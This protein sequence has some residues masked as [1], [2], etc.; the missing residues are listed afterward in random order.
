MPPN[1]ENTPQEES[2]HARLMRMMRDTTFIPQMVESFEDEIE[3]LEG[4]SLDT[5]EQV[6]WIPPTPDPISEQI[7]FESEAALNEEMRRNP[8]ILAGG[9][10]VEVGQNGSW[11]VTNS[12]RNSNP[13]PRFQGFGREFSYGGLSGFQHPSMEKSLTKAAQ[14]KL[15]KAVQALDADKKKRTEQ[16]QQLR[17]HRE[18][19]YIKMLR[20]EKRRNMTYIEIV[21]SEIPIRLQELGWN[22]VRN[23]FDA[24]RMNEVIKKDGNYNTHCANPKCKLEDVPFDYGYFCDNHLWCA[25]HVPDLKLCD[26]CMELFSTGKVVKTFDNKQIHVC[27]HCIERLY[28]YDCR[29]C[30][31]NVPLEYLQVRLC[32][33]C[34]DRNAGPRNGAHR[35]FSHGLKWAGTDSGDT[36]KSSR[37]YS[38]EIEALSPFIDHV[39]RLFKSLPLEVGIATDGSVN[40]NDGKA[41]G[42]ELQTPRLA[43]KKGEELVQRMCSAVKQVESHVNES[44]GMHVHID[45]QGLM[46]LNRKEYP[47]A[48]VQM[49]KTYII[50]E[51]V[52]M[53]LVPYSRRNNDFCRRLSESFQV[54]ELDTIETMFDVE[55]MWYKARITGDIRAA[56]G[57]HY[58]PTRYFGVNFHCLLNDGHFEIRFHPGTLNSHKILEWANMHILIADAAVRLAFTSEFLKEAQATYLL[59]EKTQL[60]FDLIGMSKPSKEFYLA[61]QRKFADKKLRDE[62]TQ[63]TAGVHRGNTLMIEEN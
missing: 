10:L 13:S 39:D 12:R 35:T 42:Y 41:F 24:I 9:A 44:C 28:R 49:W 33:Q 60:L 16:M 56:K 17:G 45:G 32:P 30:G 63:N 22:K 47:A 37:I 6:N 18:G 26:M 4:P 20:Q 50:F 31:N 57:Q 58:S 27:S 15:V 53:S 59:S 21:G 51:D 25:E 36:I 38:V 8:G 2:T 61:R 3:E 46:S 40:S 14:M 19:Q 43:G 34:I 62:E 7:V 52:L 11:I 48:L 5:P 54:N 1:A 23:I 55:K 29:S